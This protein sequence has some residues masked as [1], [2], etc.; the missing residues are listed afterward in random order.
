MISYFNTETFKNFDSKFTLRSLNKPIIKIAILLIF[1][2]VY[3]LFHKME[4]VNWYSMIA[5]YFIMYYAILLITSF[6][7]H[8]PKCDKGK[9]QFNKL[10]TLSLFYTGFAIF[11]IY[12]GAANIGVTKE[13]AA[14]YRGFYEVGLSM[15][16]G[17]IEMLFISNYD[18]VLSN[19]LSLFLTFLIINCARS[20]YRI[21][22]LDEGKGLFCGANGT[23]QVRYFADWVLRICI[24]SLFLTFEYK[25][26]DFGGLNHLVYGFSDDASLILM[27]ISLWAFLLYSVMLLWIFFTEKVIRIRLHSSTQKR[28]GWGGVIFSLV[29]YFTVA[30]P[31]FDLA[32]EMRLSHVLLLQFVV[33]VVSISSLLTSLCAMLKDFFFI[34]DES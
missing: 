8:V 32:S 9:A 14:I 28:I 10:G 15:A 3:I 19:A 31:S 33:L 6:I 1:S 7:V 13:V 18:L 27:K 23:Y 21:H 16:P 17:S 11:Y 5:S 22:E 12:S 2:F 34:D 25:I 4:E 29:F 30:L 20:Y 26:K 24:A